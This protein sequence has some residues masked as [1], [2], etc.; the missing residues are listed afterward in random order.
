[1]LQRGDR[2]RRASAA[3]RSLRPVK[4]QLDD[5]AR[6]T[7]DSFQSDERLIE[8]QEVL[9]AGI[10]GGVD[11][12]HRDADVAFGTFLGISVRA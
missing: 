10:G 2:D 8:N 6:A 11:V 9:L 1:V 7:V 4:N 12:M 5:L 3:S